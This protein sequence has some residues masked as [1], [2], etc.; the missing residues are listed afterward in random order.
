MNTSEQHPPAPDGIDVANVTSWLAAH[1]PDRAGTPR[2]TKLTGGHSNFT[3]LVEVPEGE[4]FVLRR[5]PMGELLPSAHDMGREYRIITA[6]WP[7][8]VPVPRPLAFCDDPAVTGANFYCMGLID[9]QALYEGADVRAQVPEENRRSLGFSFIDVLA[10]LHALDPDEIGLGS[11]GKKTDYV[12][13]QLH[14][15]HAS[16]KASISPDVATVTEVG[17]LHDALVDRLPEQGP[18]RVVHGDYGLHNCLSARAGH[19]AAV[20]DWEISTLGDPLADLGYAL[21]SWTDPD[22]L[23]P[24]RDEPPTLEPGFPRRAELADRYAER[25]G[26]DLSQLAYYRAFNHW[27]T[28]CIIQGVYARYL[29]G[30]KSTEG[31]DLESLVRRRDRSLELAA[32]MLESA[33]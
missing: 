6:L 7:T 10:E 3:Y 19:I 15:W 25:T 13:R 22:D 26:A 16:W 4:P 2:F 31:I 8:P 30:Q 9:G 17:R 27:K 21:N 14:R 33:G 29:H 12:A 11:L 1:L 5:P 20:V 23:D 28:T 24:T 32:E 18:A